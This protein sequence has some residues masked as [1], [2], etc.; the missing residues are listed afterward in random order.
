MVPPPVIE[1]AEKVKFYQGVV[2]GSKNHLLEMM[3]N[4]AIGKLSGGGQYTRSVTKR[5]G[6]TVE[7]VEFV[8]FRFKKG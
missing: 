6:F 5:K 8:N 2:D 4:S 7:P 3:G 1:A